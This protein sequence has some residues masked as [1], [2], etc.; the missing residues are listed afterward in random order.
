MTNKEKLFLLVDE[1]IHQH[2]EHTINI[3]KEIL[4][5]HDEENFLAF[6]EADP[7]DDEVFIQLVESKRDFMH[8]DGAWDWISPGFCHIDLNHLY[9]PCHSFITYEECATPFS[10]DPNEKKELLSILEM[11]TL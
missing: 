8:K 2:G 4:H 3:L 11:L 10:L 1:V 5:K 6:D 7:T 9:D